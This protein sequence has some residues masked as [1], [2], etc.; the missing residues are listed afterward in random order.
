MNHSSLDLK[1]RNSEINSKIE[2]IEMMINN[3][4]NSEEERKEK[5]KKKKELSNRAKWTLTGAIYT[6]FFVFV[7]DQYYFLTD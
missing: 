1:E 7:S 6:A 3:N 5:K 2:E 4:N